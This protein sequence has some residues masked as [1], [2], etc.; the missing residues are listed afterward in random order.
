[1]QLPYCLDTDDEVVSNIDVLKGGHPDPTQ[2][3]NRCELISKQSQF[4]DPS[5]FD[6]LDLLDYLGIA[7]VIY[8]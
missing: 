7:E 6:V 4:L 5:E 8:I 3:L 1:M 2:P